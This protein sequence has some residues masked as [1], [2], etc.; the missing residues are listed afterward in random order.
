MEES[1]LVLEAMASFLSIVGIFESWTRGHIPSKS[2][3][4]PDC[5]F[6]RT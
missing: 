6:P 5:V 1:Q 4:F 3:L 2:S